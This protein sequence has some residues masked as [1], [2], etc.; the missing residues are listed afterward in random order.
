MIFDADLRYTISKK[1]DVSGSLHLVY[2]TVYVCIN[3][4]FAIGLKA[5]IKI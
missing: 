4:L 5:I 3:E 1:D 2:N